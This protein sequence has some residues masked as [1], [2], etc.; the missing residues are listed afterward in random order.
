MTRSLGFLSRKIGFLDGFLDGR[1]GNAAES[2][3]EIQTAGGIFLLLPDEKFRGAQLTFRND[4]FGGRSRGI[5]HEIEKM[6]GIK[7]R[8]RK[9]FRLLRHKLVYGA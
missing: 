5:A 8:V 7:A 2:A 9:N 1:K 4:F 3:R 6:V